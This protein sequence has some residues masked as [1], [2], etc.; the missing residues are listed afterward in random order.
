VVFLSGCLQESRTSNQSISKQKAI[1]IAIESA[2]MSH[3]ELSGS[4]VP[5]SNIRAQQM[6]LEEAT[7]RIYEGNHVGDGYAPDMLVWIVTMDGMWLDEFPRPTDVPA[8]KPYRHLVMI[9]NAKTGEEIESAAR[10]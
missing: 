1:E 3:P 7:R 2:S 6:T 4:Q 10:P 5:P 9:L 8:P